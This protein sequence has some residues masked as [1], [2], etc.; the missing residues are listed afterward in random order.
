MLIHLLLG[1]EILA[2]FFWLKN[3]LDESIARIEN[4]LDSIESNLIATNQQAT[5]PEKRA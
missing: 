1:I 5:E 4:R 2:G 3:S